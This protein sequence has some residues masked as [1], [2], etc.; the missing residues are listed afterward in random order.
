[1]IIDRFAWD[2]YNADA[3]HRPDNVTKAANEKMLYDPALAP[4]FASLNELIFS[5]LKSDCRDAV[6]CYALR[7]RY[8]QQLMDGNDSV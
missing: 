7:E 5:W 6:A 3:F 8:R 1:M 2:F 4:W